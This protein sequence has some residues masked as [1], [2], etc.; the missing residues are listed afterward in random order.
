VSGR[1]FLVTDFD[2]T[3]LRSDSTLAAEDLEALA[4]AGR[5]GAIRVLATGRSLFSLRR[6][7]AGR[8]LPLDYIVF[9]TGAG[10]ARAADGEVLEARSLSPP[11]VGRAAEALAARGLCYMVH[12]PIPDNH[13][14]AW[15]AA[16]EVP[17]DFPRRIALYEGHCR[18]L[19]GESAGFGPAAQLLA[20]LPPGR[21]VDGLR[22]DLGGLSVV[23]ATS[24]LDHASTWVE[25]FAPGVSKGSAVARLAARLGGDAAAS[26]AVGNDYNDEDILAWAGT[27]RVTANAPESMRRRHPVV[28]GND[29]AGVAAAVREW[30]E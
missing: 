15:R 13:R 16:A 8:E 10:V 9:S 19:S 7:L 18:P 25:V 28:P 24:P 17:P 23:C 11:Q 5:R 2:G 27:A 6:T 21:S 4:A 26:L 20:I 3:L 1:P 22:G 30:L 29:H 14:F 12:E